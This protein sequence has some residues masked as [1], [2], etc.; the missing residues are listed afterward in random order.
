MDRK[1]FT[2]GTVLVG[3]LH[4]DEIGK[5]E[6]DTW[7]QSEFRKEWSECDY[8]ETH[9]GHLH[10]E[11][12]F[13][14]KGGITRRTNPTLKRKD[15]YEYDHA[16]SSNKVVLGYLWHKTENLKEVYYFK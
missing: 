12:L 14:E 2:Y 3:L 1:I 9:C 11:Q 8:A 7:L 4:G 6:I 15:K 16:W 10:Q 13:K 5:D